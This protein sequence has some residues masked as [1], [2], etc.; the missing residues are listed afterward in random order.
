MSVLDYRPGDSV[1][2]RMDPRVKMVLLVALSATVF[3]ISHVAVL[4][5]L[6]LG[7]LLIWKAGGLPLGTMA[8]YLRFLGGLVLFLVV[9]QGLFYS[10]GEDPVVLVRP[11]FPAGIPLLGGRGAI[12]RDGILLGLVLGFRLFVL[13]CLMPVL[14][15][16]TPLSGA[17]RGLVRMG[18]N[19]KYAYMAITAMNLIPALQKE[20]KNVMDAQKMRGLR[21]FESGR[22]PARLRAY[23]TLVVPLVVGSMRR[24]QLMGVAMEARAFGA[25]P[26]RTSRRDLVMRRGDWL[27]LAAGVLLCAGL[28]WYNRRLGGWF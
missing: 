7:V 15:M 27:A 21:A 25:F 23:A 14:V 18:I 17:A 5:V 3:L 1:V 13:V 2:H 12:Y 20:A 24:A 6:F 9:L 19:Y 28:L 8:R 4:T 26:T 11:L 10:F 22:L 16:T